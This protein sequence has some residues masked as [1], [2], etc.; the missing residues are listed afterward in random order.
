M[1]GAPVHERQFIRLDSPRARRFTTLEVQLF[2][3][4]DTHIQRCAVGSEASIRRCFG[5]DMQ[6]LY[7]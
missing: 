7:A 2:R 3:V 1:I 4:L 5:A 6:Q